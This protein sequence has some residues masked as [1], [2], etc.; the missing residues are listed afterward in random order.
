M[1][2]ASSVE[3]ITT[4]TNNSS[5]Q[6]KENRMKATRIIWPGERVDRYLAI[7][8]V[9]KSTLQVSAMLMCSALVMRAIYS[10]HIECRLN[11]FLLG[12]LQITAIFAHHRQTLEI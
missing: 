1:E 7:L 12:A 4:R 8:L 10:I 11:E 9:S 3:N 5:K 6:K 2:S